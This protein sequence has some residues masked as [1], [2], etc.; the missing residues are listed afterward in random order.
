MLVR[1]SKYDS[2]LRSIALLIGIFFLLGASCG[3]KSTSRSV[4]KGSDNSALAAMDRAQPSPKPAKKK[5][6]FVDMAGLKLPSMSSVEK[7]KFHV[8]CQELES[9]CGKVEDLCTALRSCKKAKSVALFVAELV[10]D[11]ASD[12]EVRG[13]YSEVFLKKVELRTFN[14]EGAPRVG[15]KDATLT[16]VE[17]YDYGCSACRAFSPVFLELASEFDTE[18]AF[19]FLQYPLTSHPFSKFAARAALAADKQGKFLLFHKWLL[20]HPDQ[21]GEAA[22]NKQ[23][24]ALGLDMKKYKADY[25]SAADVVERQRKEGTKNG[26]DG[27]PSVFLNGHDFPLIRDLKYL[28]LVVQAELD[29]Q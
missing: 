11:G 19:Y 9:P 28:K 8:L 18:L 27:T 16:M 20:E 10:K 25:E 26:V 15:P 3:D 23:A 13:I 2:F 14:L 6:P 29:G 24:K 4:S 21:H 5:A 17:Y 22:L 1:T 12:T 7:K